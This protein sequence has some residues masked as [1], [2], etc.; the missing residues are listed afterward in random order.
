LVIGDVGDLGHSTEAEVTALREKGRKEVQPQVRGD[1]GSAPPACSN[2]RVNSVHPSTSITSV[3]GP[4]RGAQFQECT[5]LVV[6]TAL[7]GTLVID[8]EVL[9]DS[10]G[11]F[12]QAKTDGW[13][14]GSG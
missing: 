8:D 11:S 12:L 1:D 14:P 13:R 3:T 7:G 9:P 2:H 10:S 4:Q 5:E 6:A